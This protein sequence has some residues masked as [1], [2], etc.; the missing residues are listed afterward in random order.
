MTT[1]L[2]GDI[3]GTN[4]RLAYFDAEGEKLTLK[5]EKHYSSKEAGSLTEIVAR[6]IE[7]HGL[8]TEHACFAIAGPVRNGRVRAPNLP[9]TADAADMSSRLDIPNVQLIN[10]L[11][12]NAMGIPALTDEEF[13]VLNE[14]VADPHGTIA[15]IS[16]G[17]GLGQTCGYW[18]GKAHRPLPSEGGHADFAPRNE[19][20][21]ELLLYLRSV[22]GRVSIE[23]V[24]SGPGLRNIYQFL[25]D[26]KRTA[27]TPSVAEEMQH[28]SD[29]SAVITRAAMDGES[30]LCSQVL[31]M[32]VS[33]YGA[34][35]GNAALRY[36]STG[37]MYLGGGI[38]PKILERLK[39][40]GFMM[41]YTTKGRLS[42]V[43]E[44]I[45]VK[46]ILNDRTA[47]LGAARSALLAM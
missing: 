26:V 32:F 25:R 8:H 10:D 21:S 30:P 39:G 29:A 14:G 42:T 7:E 36:L 45:P 11:S 9:W 43:I 18:D 13:V 33:F 23:R 47:L 6:F 34:E 27:E 44:T 37:G 35:A 5:V 41:A 4:T 3:G 15:L 38:A 1:V 24:L 28:A 16:A 31:D 46:V 12:A 22:Y 19:L 2:A 17:T 20:E 40:P